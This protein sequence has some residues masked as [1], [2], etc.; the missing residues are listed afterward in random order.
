MMF[1]KN[2]LLAIN[3]FFCSFSG[4]PDLGPNTCEGAGEPEVEHV[5][6]SLF[7]FPG[8]ILHPLHGL[9]HHVLRLPASETPNRQQ[10]QQQGQ[11]SL[12]PENAS[13]T[14]TVGVRAPIGQFPSNLLNW[15][16]QAFPRPQ[17]LPLSSF[18][19]SA[20]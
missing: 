16:V 11:H 6:S 2:A 10:N 9:L 7:L 3:S 19:L 14:V 20:S 4:T 8:L 12:C 18:P 15:K 13:G 1:T 17:Q 5:W